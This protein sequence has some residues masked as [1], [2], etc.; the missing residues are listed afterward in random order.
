MH[1]TIVSIFPELFESFLATSLLQKAQ[2]SQ[3]LTFELV[4][5]RDFCSDKHQQVDDQVYG[6]GKGMLLKAQPLIDA[7]E[8]VIQKYALQESDFSLLF[9]AP[10]QEVF[11]QKIAYGLSKKEHLIIVCGRYE[12]IDHRFDLYFQQKYPQAFRRLSLGSF[13]LL[14][15]EVASMVMIEAITRL[16]PGVIKEKQSWIEESYAL[17]EG[18]KNLEAPNYTRPEEVYGMRVPEV[19]LKGDKAAVD[20]WKNE[21]TIRI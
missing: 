13:V 9:P 14:G 16:I 10:A 8:A 18:M 5:P 20:A 19:L 7:V 6:N 12:G 3:I 17:Q 21:H 1:I 2:K 15:G 11:S 4:N